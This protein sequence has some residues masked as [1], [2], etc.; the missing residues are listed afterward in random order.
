[1]PL[2]LKTGCCYWTQWRCLY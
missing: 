1:L 2:C